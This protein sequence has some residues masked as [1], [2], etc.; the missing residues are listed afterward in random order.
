MKNSRGFT[1]IEL[2]VVIVILAIGLVG[3][4][5]MFTAGV[6]SNKKAA[7]M[8]LA[9]H[10]ANQEIERLRDAGFWGAVVDSIH[11]PSPRYTIISPTRVSFTVPELTD[12]QGY[13]DLDLDPEA[14]VIDP[15][16]GLYLGNLEQVRVSISWGGGKPVRGNY[17]IFTL[18]ANR[19]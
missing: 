10:R 18:I 19:P 4:A 15:V 9:S 13:L 14:K 16:T 17:S 8:T 3:V 2:I 7:N 11:F 6:I 5:G 1:L 12:G